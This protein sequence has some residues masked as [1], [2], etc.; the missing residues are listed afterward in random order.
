MLEKDGVV[1]DGGSASLEEKLRSQSR[2]SDE[3]GEKDWA[4]DGQRRT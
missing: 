4:S 1:V 2:R 3:E